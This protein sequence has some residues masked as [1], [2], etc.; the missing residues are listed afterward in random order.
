MKNLKSIISVLIILAAGIWIAYGGLKAYQNY[1]ASN[2]PQAMTQERLEE[3]AAKGEAEAQYQLALKYDNGRGVDVDK[4]KALDLYLKAAEQGHVKA[5]NNLAILYE[6]AEGTHVNL[7]RA[8]YWYL[9]AANGGYAGAQ[10][11]LGLLYYQSNPK[12]NLDKAIEW[13][14]KAA[15]QDYR[16]A[17]YNLGY[18]YITDKN[19]PDNSLKWYLRAAENGNVR[20]Q[21]SAG[22]LLY[23][24]KEYG[25]ALKWF[26]R[27]AEQGDKEAQNYLGVLYKNGQGTA[28]NYFEAGK[29]FKEA[30]KNG[31]QNT[32]DYLERQN[33]KCLDMRVESSATLGSCIM[34]AVAGYP[35]PQ[36][37]L[38]GLYRHGDQVVQDNEKSRYWWEKASLQGEPL[39]QVGLILHYVHERPAGE[40]VKKQYPGADI[41]DNFYKAYLWTKVLD[42]NPRKSE[43]PENWTAHTTQ[44]IKSVYDIK[45]KLLS[46]KPLHKFDELD[47][48]AEVFYQDLEKFLTC[49]QISDEEK[50]DE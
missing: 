14:V 44:T 25:E 1:S 9:K 5:Q 43:I 13:L 2:Q 47:Q 7:E 6:K 37:I 33:K 28:Q 45:E 24:K 10:A 26:Q 17:E 42:S 22:T 21:Y 31:N 34:A 29:W 12:K 48:C 20:A 23:K 39:S 35:K 38:G 27:P 3:R 32:K 50:R 16:Q 40:I 15:E 30:V 41:L 4:K 18:L 11:N 46:I 36:G 8:E 49:S 19:D